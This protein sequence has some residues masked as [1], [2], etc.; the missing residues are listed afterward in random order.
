MLSMSNTSA[1]LAD[2]KQQFFT[3][4][5][6][7]LVRTAI[8]LA[9]T[10]TYAGV[11]SST[12][13]PLALKANIGTYAYSME[14]QKDDSSSERHLV[15]Y[16]SIDLDIFDIGAPGLS[17]HSYTR[18]LNNPYRAD[19]DG[20]STKIYSLYMQY[21]ASSLRG[22]IRLGRQFVYS[23][24]ARGKMDGA[25]I[26]FTPVDGVSLTGFLG[27]AEPEDVSTRLDSWSS[28][29]M[30][31]CRMQV[32]RIPGTLAA[33]SFSQHTR[34]GDVEGRLI[35]IDLR[36]RSVSGLDLYG[37]FDW[38]LM[39]GR[40]SYLTLRASSRVNNRLSFSGEFERHNPQVRSNS[41]LSVFRQD[42][43]N[44]VRVRPYLKLGGRLGLE[45]GYSLVS[46]NAAKTHRLDAGLDFGPGRIGLI[47]RAGYGGNTTGGYGSFQIEP[48]NSLRVRLSADFQ[49]YRIV[50]DVSPLLESFVTSVA[51][52]YDGL[53]PLSLS[54]EFQE[55][56]NPVLN[57][58]F[59][60]YAG[61]NYKFRSAR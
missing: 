22:M 21:R 51:F 32:Q 3:P 13:N 37:R 31:G 4:G 35:G 33:W 58:D 50:E 11:A 15:S 7:I 48:L 18:T 23:G 14:E 57:S 9:L 59:R 17:F 5:S 44:Q 29:N 38:D 52:D 19:L 24:V 39:A 27:T 28:S 61:A 56:R 54:L 55:A 45:G 8:T 49:R 25:R 26:D 34:N 1:R 6:N 60:I 20:P 30:W 40:T 42:A 47:Y 43:Y 46:Y 53:R 10:F 41:I 2:D 36:N 16:E 12:E